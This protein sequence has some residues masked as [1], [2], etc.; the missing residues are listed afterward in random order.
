[1]AKTGNIVI[2]GLA[3]LAAGLAIGVLFAPDKGWKTRKRIQKTLEDTVESVKEGV[4]EKLKD[5]KAYVKKEYDKAADA[6]KG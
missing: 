5:A 3:G 6:I 4:E 2:A 1:M